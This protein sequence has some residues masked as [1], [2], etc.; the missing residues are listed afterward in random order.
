M[1]YVRAKQCKQTAGAEMALLCDR[2]AERLAK[3]TA[4]F[5]V[6]GTTSYEEVLQRDD[7]DEERPNGHF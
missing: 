2:D 7:V 1:G 4:E 6:S 5:E 3:N